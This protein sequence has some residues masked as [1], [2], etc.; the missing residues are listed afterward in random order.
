MQYILSMKLQG[1]T[2]VQ[3]SISFG[4]P[5]I[6]LSWKVDFE[7][8]DQCVFSKLQALY[9]TQLDFWIQIPPSCHLQYFLISFLFLKKKWFQSLLNSFSKQNFDPLPFFDHEKKIMHVIH[10]N[11]K[12]VQTVDQ[13]IV[14]PWD[15]KQHQTLLQDTCC[16]KHEHLVRNDILW[17]LSSICPPFLLQHIT[18]LIVIEVVSAR[19]IL[20]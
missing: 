17:S 11:Q 13:R 19:V 18:I 10:K 4:S 2:K 3:L 20:L 5:C 9:S 7:Q 14:W 15:F 8:F 16:S 6:I 12:T 1:E